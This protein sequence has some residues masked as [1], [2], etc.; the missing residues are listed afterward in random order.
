MVMMIQGLVFSGFPGRDAENL[1]RL[2]YAGRVEWFRHRFDLVFMTPFRRLVELEGPDCYV[3]LCIMT[4]CGAA[5]HALANLAIGRGSDPEKFSAF[6]NTYLPT[7]A[8]ADFELNDSRAGRPNEVARTPAE[9]FYKF[10]R[11]GLA[12]SFCID[13]GGIQHREEL[14]NIGQ[15]YLFQT[16]QGFQGEHGLGIVPREFVQDF[17]GACER[18]L[19]AF[20]TALPGDELREAFDRTF[21]RVFLRKAR[22]PLP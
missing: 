10:F 1:R 12:H 9:H 19:I 20:A 3:W 4:L 15:D 13:W 11:N 17:E 8:H 16:T 14:P 7:F 22:A 6:L 21:S 2:D 18:L 5:I